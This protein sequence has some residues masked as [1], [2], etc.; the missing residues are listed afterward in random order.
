VEESIL[1]LCL[2]VAPFLTM[3][4]IMVLN[5]LAVARRADRRERCDAIRLRAALRA[6]LHALL[7]LYAENLRLVADHEG[8][9]LSGRPLLAV[10]RANLGRLITLTEGEIATL[11]ACSSALERLEALFAVH[12]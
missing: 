11:V 5:Q 3:G 2:H 4:L 10:Y 12:C 7:G 6:E 1:Q 9:M 8:Y